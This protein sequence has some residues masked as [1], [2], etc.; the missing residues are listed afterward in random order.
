ML[1]LPLLLT[2]RIWYR[3]VCTEPTRVE[4]MISSW[5]NDMPYEI[6]EKDKSG[7]NSE[8][9][10]I[11]GDNFRDNSRDNSGGGEI[12]L[13][14]TR[15]VEEALAKVIF[16]SKKVCFIQKNYVFIIKSYLFP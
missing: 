6:E 10:E 9:S 2:V 12:T 15:D 11:P 14:I 7:D 13:E 8:D 16:I 3:W 4:S 5:T 1:G